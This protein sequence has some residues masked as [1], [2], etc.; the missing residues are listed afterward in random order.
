MALAK[1]QLCV[2]QCQVTRLDDLVYVLLGQLMTLE[3]RFTHVQE[4][5]LINS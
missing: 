1:L 2:L 4:N 3:T 5:H